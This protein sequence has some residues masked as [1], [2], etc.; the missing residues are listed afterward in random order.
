MWSIVC[1]ALALTACA[2]A[3]VLVPAST[4]TITVYVTTTISTDVVTVTATSTVLTTAFVTVTESATT[5][6]S[7][8]PV[9]TDQAYIDTILRH[10]NLHRINHTSPNLIWDSDLAEKARTITDTCIYQLDTYVPP[11]PSASRPPPNISPFTPQHIL[12]Q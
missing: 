4:A 1:T 5:T 3:Q 9:V 7:D 2:Q 10:H 8:G 11:H 6:S 12:T